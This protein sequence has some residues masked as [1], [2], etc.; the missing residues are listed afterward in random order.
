MQ[1]LNHI[2]MISADDI[3]YEDNHIIALRK[4][5]GEIVQGD[6]TGDL[7]LS[8]Q[9]KAYIKV[10]YHKPGNVFVGVAHRLDRPVSGAI[11]FART[12]KGLA[13]LNEMFRNGLFEK[14]YWAVVKLRPEND[15][16]KLVHYMIK[17]EKQNKS[18]LS[19]SE[20]PGWKKAELEYRYLASSDNYHLLE[21]TLLTGRHH[22]IRAQ[23]AAIGCPVKGD[24]K[25]GYPRSNPDG[26]ISLHARY[27]TFTHPVRQ[28]K[29]EI[30][31]PVPED[32]VW[33]TLYGQWVSSMENSNG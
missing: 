14:K 3:L 30:V 25:Y 32:K 4:R 31:C 11:L 19:D 26:S 5:A 27:I 18:Y 20:K 33:Q 6:K 29:V 17:N 10:R 1:T 12:S 2:N 24:L 22:Q 16:G 23:L 21:I 9:L 8:E 13:R 7:P 15:S 28:D